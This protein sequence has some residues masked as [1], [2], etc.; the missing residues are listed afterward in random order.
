MEALRIP[1][2]LENRL[3][4]GASPTEKEAEG[5]AVAAGDALQTRPLCGLAAFHTNS[6]AVA[7][8][9]ESANTSVKRSSVRSEAAD[10]SEYVHGRSCKSFGSN[11][12]SNLT[13]HS[14]WRTLCGN[15]ASDVSLVVRFI[16]AEHFSSDGSFLFRWCPIISQ[17]SQ[18]LWY[19]NSSVV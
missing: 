14:L 12:H 11:I 8:V 18:L 6:W 3:R 17:I 15:V 7:Q 19:R 4:D 1:H 13:S 2:C 16:G 10:V 5:G 9:V